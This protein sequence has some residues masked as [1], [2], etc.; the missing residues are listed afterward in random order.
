MKNNEQQICIKTLTG[1]AFMLKHDNTT[2][3]GGFARGISQHCFPGFKPAS[4]L[5]LANITVIF[6]GKVMTA[7]T[8]DEHR[9]EFQ[10]AACV[11]AVVTRG[12]ELDRYLQ[13]EPS[14]QFDALNDPDKCQQ[15]EPT[16][17]KLPMADVLS[18]PTPLLSLQQALI[19]HAKVSGIS[20]NLSLLTGMT[21]FASLTFGGLSAGGAAWLSVSS[22][23]AMVTGLNSNAIIVLSVVAVFAV[24]ALVF[25]CLGAKAC[26]EGNQ[27]VH[28]TNR[29]FAEN[30]EFQA[31]ENT[32]GI[33]VAEIAI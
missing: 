3:L 19:D 14:N 7:S 21:T 2:T 4:G 26:H 5:Y 11:H 13:G 10:K 33:P 15:P 28:L 20:K 18:D 30:R 8:F 32:S 23:L 27:E 16:L 22:N 9:P 17:G 31:P 25:A 24:A 12:S 1:H 29:I 6:S